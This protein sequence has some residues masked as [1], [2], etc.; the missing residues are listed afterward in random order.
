MNYESF[1]L[2][3]FVTESNQIE[4]IPGFSSADYDA[5]ARLLT[6]TRL[7]VS[8]LIAFVKGV[9]PNAVLRDQPGLNV[10]VGR[11]RPPEGGLQIARELAL[12]LYDADHGP[13][14]YEIYVKG[15]IDR[16]SPY[17]IHRR[18]ETLHPF[19]DGN[20]RSGRAL[21]LYMMGGIERAPLGFLRTWYGTGPTTEGDRI[22]EG[23]PL[24][25]YLLREHYYQS[26]QASR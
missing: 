19:T 24:E 12:I 6:R 11:H 15:D 21:W 22:D 8:E 1:T 16:F 2:E 17:E 25:F 5:H 9:Q 3:D 7:S 4:G 20:G 26:L 14:S 10:I 18:Y 13:D 23:N